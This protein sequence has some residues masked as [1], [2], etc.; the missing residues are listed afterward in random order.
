M[1]WRSRGYLPHLEFAGQV[2]AVTFRLC[3]S[4]PVVVVQ[5][6]AE[7]LSSNPH[8]DTTDLR[9]RELRKRI[10]TYEDAGYGS[11]YLANPRVADIVE[12]T[13][14]HGHGAAYTLHGWCV[15]PNHVHVIVEPTGITAL[16]S[17]VHA[18]KSVSARRANAQLGRTGQF[19]LRE[20]YDRYIRDDVHLAA[21]IRYTEHNPVAAG[22]C[23]SPDDWLWSSASAHRR[24]IAVTLPRQ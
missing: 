22:L 16:S 12:A 18:W 17:I 15:M 19:W 2:Q 6:W 4:V 5:R 8:I 7:E 23:V 1:G 11:C 3:D 21:A 13:L 9:A 24:G 10:A 14:I 20:Y